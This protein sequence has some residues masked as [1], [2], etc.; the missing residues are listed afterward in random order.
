MNHQPFREWLLLDE[1]LTSEQAMALADH[2]SSC[3]ACTQL[4][5]AWKEAEL[6][7]R[8]N[9]QV[10]PLPGF[11]TRWQTHLQTY[12]ARQQA[13]K[14]WLGIAA[15]GLLAAILVFI[16]FAQVWSLVQSPGQYLA[17]WLDRLIGILSIFYALQNL[18]SSYSWPIPIYTYIGMFFLLGLI[19]FLS[20][21]WLAAY[22]KI[23]LSRRVA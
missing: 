3:E 18:V 5:S 11:T 12:Q 8:R 20:V 7:I 16:V 9:P 2:L 14:G 21:L 13:R 6:V 1:H 23:S 19:S 17:F 4:E 15:T 10:E 22:R